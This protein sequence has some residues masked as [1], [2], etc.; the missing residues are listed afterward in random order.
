[1]L[2][3]SDHAFLTGT[4]PPS[5][6]NLTSLVSL[7]LARN[8]LSGTIPDG[9]SDLSN[10]VFF[11]LVGNDDLSGSLEELCEAIDLATFERAVVGCNVECSCCDQECRGP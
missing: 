7:D 9:I 11:Q 3:P 10:L 4:I 1:M 2:D 8:D 5:L 6:G